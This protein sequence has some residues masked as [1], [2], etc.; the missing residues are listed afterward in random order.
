MNNTWRPRDFE[1]LRRYSYISFSKGFF[2]G[3]IEISSAFV[4]M[5]EGSYAWGEFTSW[6]TIER[7]V[8]CK[9]E[10]NIFIVNGCRKQ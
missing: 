6:N 3:D 9:G 4:G 1:N 7:D 10:K 2:G 5:M 8:D